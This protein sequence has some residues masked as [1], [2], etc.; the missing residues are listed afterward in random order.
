MLRNARIRLALAASALGL[1]VAALVLVVFYRATYAV[2]EAETRQVVTTELAGLSDDYHALGVLGLARAI[3]RRMQDA[4]ERDAVYLLT[5]RF[6]RKLT[7]NLQA[8]PATVSPGSGWVTLDL[9]RT[10]SA[11]SSTIS[12]ASVRLPGG[13]RLLVG[14]DSAA[15]QTFETALLRA[16]AWALGAA[17]L[18]SVVTGWLLSRLVFNRIADISDTAATIIGGDLDRRVP[19]RGTGDEL[20]RLSE[21]LNAMLDRIGALVTHLRTTTDS[22]A[23]D[24]RSPLTRLHGQ[25]GALAD[26]DLDDSARQEL[27]ARALD[28]A[29]HLLRVF[30]ALTEIARAEA[31]LGRQAFEPVDLTALIAEL[32][33]LYGPVAADT[34]V[35]IVTEGAAPPLTGN[36]TLLAQA[37]SNLIENALRYAPADSTITLSLEPGDTATLLTV[38]DQGPGIDA[39]DRDRV[40]DRFVTLDPAR[41]DRGTGLGLALANAVARLHG[42][43]LTLEDNA[44]GLRAEL[45]LSASGTACQSLAVLPREEDRKVR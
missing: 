10:D 34:G 8:W 16:A 21:T 43:R 40:L 42:G 6:G 23:H 18:L 35:R 25:I 5:D 1:L 20:D 32:A 36:R 27:A 19:V 45:W 33:E 22:L 39:A 14:R 29:G 13:E 3:D 38:A 11:R 9:Y 24:L 12:A 37:V 30:T 4:A 41:T 31:G 28:E 7:G 17:A 44:P 15:R 26:P 2:V